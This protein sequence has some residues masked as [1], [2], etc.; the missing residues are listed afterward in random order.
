M[1]KIHILRNFGTFIRNIGGILL[2]WYVILYSYIWIAL[3]FAFIYNNNPYTLP[4]SVHTYSHLLFS[5][6]VYLPYVTAITILG[7]YIRF[8]FSFER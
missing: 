2:L 4:L 6:F 8:I 1:D 3:N 5:T 7:E